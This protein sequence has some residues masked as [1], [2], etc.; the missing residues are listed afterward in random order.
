MTASLSQL[1]DTKEEL[2]SGDSSQ[3]NGIAD[4]GQVRPEVE[5]DF[6][7]IGCGG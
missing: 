5:A 4:R 7:L 2:V 3:N 1:E 6:D